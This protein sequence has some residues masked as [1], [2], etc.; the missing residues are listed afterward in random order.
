MISLRQLDE[1]RSIQ[2]KLLESG[3]L[4]FLDLTKKVSVGRSNYW[5]VDH[6]KIISYCI[7]NDIKVSK[8]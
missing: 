2:W 8:I 1:V 5:L 4:E 6:P 7:L 3:E